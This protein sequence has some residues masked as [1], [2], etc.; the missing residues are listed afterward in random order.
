MCEEREG[1]S[2]RLNYQVTQAIQLSLV[3][4][5]LPLSVRLGDSDPSWKHMLSITHLQKNSR[6]SP[7]TV[8][9]GSDR[10]K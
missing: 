2:D 10:L 7:S 6:L 1:T 4:L 8:S 3:L 9:N 5:A